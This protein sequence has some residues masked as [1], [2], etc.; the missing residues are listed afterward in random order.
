MI[1]GVA[2]SQLLLPEARD[3]DLGLPRG[4]REPITHGSR[5][6]MGGCRRKR[7]GMPISYAVA[8]RHTPMVDVVGSDTYRGCTQCGAAA[9]A[10]LHRACTKTASPV[11]QV[12]SGLRRLGQP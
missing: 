2:M 3:P 10:A 11:S 4:G 6:H 9:R 12:C 7:A 5:A 1:G 8:R